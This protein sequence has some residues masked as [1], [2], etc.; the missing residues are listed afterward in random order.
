MHE[1]SSNGVGVGIA[2][3]L[4][5]EEVAPDERGESPVWF[6]LAG[7]VVGIAGVAKSTLTRSR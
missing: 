1:P 3:E 2:L 5:A 6:A 7:V 4:F